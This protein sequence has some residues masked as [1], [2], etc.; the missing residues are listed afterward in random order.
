MDTN[1]EYRDIQKIRNFTDLL[2]WQKGHQLALDVYK[3]T[4]SFPKEEMFALSSQLRRAVISV[5]SNI[6]EGFGRKTKD[7]KLH[8][9]RMAAGSLFEVQNQLILCRDLE[10]IEVLQYN[11]I[12]AIA[13]SA[14]KLCSA[15]IRKVGS[16]P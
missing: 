5:T 12:S 13:E 7:D 2:V 8:F 9:Y 6:A 1:K 15:T 3:A 11:K 16:L 14:A 10:Y 4:R